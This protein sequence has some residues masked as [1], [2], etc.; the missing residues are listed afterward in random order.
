M[1]VA[2]ILVWWCMCP[3]IPEN[4]RTICIDTDSDGPTRQTKDPN[5]KRSQAKE[6]KKKEGKDNDTDTI[7]QNKSKVKHTNPINTHHAQKNSES[8]LSSQSTNEKVHDVQK[9]NDISQTCP[10]QNSDFRLREWHPLSTF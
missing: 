2:F 1:T 6:N 8:T 9:L 3:Y 10:Q 4:F 7:P 5:S